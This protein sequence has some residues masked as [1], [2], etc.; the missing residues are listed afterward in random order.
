G[1]LEPDSGGVY[2]CEFG[3]CSFEAA[4]TATGWHALPACNSGFRQRAIGTSVA[5][6]WQ[7]ERFAFDLGTTR[8]GFKVTNWTGGIGYSGK[9][10]SLAWRITASR[11]PM[12]NSLHSFAGATE[13]STGIEAGGV[14]ATGGALSLSWDQGHEK[15]VSAEIS[16]HRL[17]GK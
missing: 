11:R 9:L 2:R 12:T 5:L 15:G 6:G 13:P 17:I 7:G 14:M 4:N 16:H 8:M 3:S 1:T 10:G